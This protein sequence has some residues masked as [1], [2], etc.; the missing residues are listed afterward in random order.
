[1]IIK[2]LPVK[3]GVISLLQKRLQFDLDTL[4]DLHKSYGCCDVLLEDVTK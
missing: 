3:F 1:M 4:E 2:T